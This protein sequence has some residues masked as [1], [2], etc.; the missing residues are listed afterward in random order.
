MKKTNLMFWPNVKVALVLFA[1][2]GIL[3]SCSSDDS[4]DSGDDG[5]DLEL[6][7]QEGNPRF[8]LQFTNGDNVDLDLYVETPNGVTIYYGNTSGD[9]G[10]LD[11]D[12]LC[13]DCPQ[14][15]NENI[16]WES[17]TAPSGTYKYWVD[18][19]DDCGNGGSSDFTL[20]V[21]KNGTVLATKTGTLSSGQTTEWTHEQP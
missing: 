14:G 2:F 13:D 9:N 18:Y 20:R 3:L 10:E 16:F 11:V 17:G 8:N 21:I 6:V 4:E 7:G 19:Y 12:C 5:D 1:F 15:P